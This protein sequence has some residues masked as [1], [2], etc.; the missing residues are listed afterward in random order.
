MMAISTDTKKQIL[1]LHAAGVGRNSI[2]SRLTGVSA[3]VVR[4]VV[5]HESVV[6]CGRLSSREVSSL[7]MKMGAT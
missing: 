3:G 4:K 1:E 2:A 6:M 5:N 7:L